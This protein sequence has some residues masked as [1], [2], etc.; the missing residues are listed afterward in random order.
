MR[1]KNKI[2]IVTGGTSGIGRRVVERFC[3][4]GAKVVFTGRRA[5]LGNEIAGIN[6]AT[7]IEADAGSETDTTRT[8]DQTLDMH[9]RIDVLMNNAGG[10]TTSGRLEELSLEEFDQTIQVHVR[11]Y[12]AHMKYAAPSMRA[13]GMGSII[14]VGSVAGHRA[15]YS[16]SLIYAVSKAAVIHLTRCA[17]MELGEDNI[18]VNSISPGGIATGIFAKSLGM[19]EEQAE[20]TTEQVK[21][22]LATVQAIPR[23]GI[24]DDIAAAAVYLA[25]DE[26][27]F[28]NGEDIVIDG[29]LIW[30]RRHSDVVKGGG[31]WRQLFD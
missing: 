2:A 13:Q 15:G 20:A 18:R 11:G 30:G 31:T 10:P 8:I 22:A 16:S 28:V 7:F 12:L 27:S 23:A 1:L 5:D 24:T 3:A 21:E 17:A 29:G 6:N 25:S 14:N 26:A 9:G 19:D 4:E